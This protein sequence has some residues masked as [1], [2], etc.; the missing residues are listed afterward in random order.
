MNLGTLLEQVKKEKPTGLSHE[1]LTT[2]ANEVE[3]ILQ[4]YQEV[5]LGERVSYVWPEDSEEDL[6]A[7]EPYSRLYAF[8]IKACIDYANEELESY[9][10]NMAQ[11][12]LAY[13]EWVDFII[14]HGGV[15]R[16]A[17]VKVKGWW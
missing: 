14:R 12:E 1:Y 17:P 9:E 13:S 15:P 3:H 6:L 10:N 4:D 7:P 2:K 16:T 11:F 8:Y 5:P